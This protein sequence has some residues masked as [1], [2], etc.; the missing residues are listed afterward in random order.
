MAFYTFRKVGL[1]SVRVQVDNCKYGLKQLQKLRCGCVAVRSLG[2]L[3][4][5]VLESSICHFVMTPIISQSNRSPQAA[6]VAPMS[7]QQ[8]A[9]MII[10]QGDMPFYGACTYDMNIMNTWRALPLSSSNV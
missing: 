3:N 8:D 2:C 1:G 4:S 7:P 6:F 9:S 5:I 10:I